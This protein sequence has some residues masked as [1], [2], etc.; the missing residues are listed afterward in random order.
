[1][2]NNTMESLLLE[3]T[4]LSQSLAVESREKL[5]DNLRS[6]ALSL[7]T[8]SQTWVRLLENVAEP[9]VLRV[10]VDLKIF[11]ILH[12]HHTPM[13]LRELSQRSG[14]EEL[15]LGRLMR[16]ATATGMVKE[17]GKDEYEKNEVT[18]LFAGTTGQSFTR[19][20]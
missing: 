10:L 5:V 2:P 8:P 20:L 4:S 6:L 19:F 17:V 13:G 16:C 9:A 15:L 14:A 7:E 11:E 12:D 18:K 3:I 1:M